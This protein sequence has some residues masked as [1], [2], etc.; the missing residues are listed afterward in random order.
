MSG[1]DS[2]AHVSM[3]RVHRVSALLKRG[4]LGTHHGAVNHFNSTTIS[5]GLCFAS[6]AGHRVF[7]RPARLP[8]A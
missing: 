2:P 4:L 7:S 5:T 3:L 6:I 8:P 1:A